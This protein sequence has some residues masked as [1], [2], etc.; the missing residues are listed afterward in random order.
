MK[1]DSPGDESLLSNWPGL[2]V[3]TT[4]GMKY[5]LHMYYVIGSNFAF[6]IKILTTHA[7]STCHP[8]A[9]L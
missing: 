3:P 8:P 2:T 7:L 5:L 6:K 1:V 9:A 4:P